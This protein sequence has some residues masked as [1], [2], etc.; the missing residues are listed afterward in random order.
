M[1][2]PEPAPASAPGPCLFSLAR[3][4]R[5]D[6]ATHLSSSHLGDP[7]N[8]LFSASDLAMQPIIPCEVHEDDCGPETTAGDQSH[9]T[10][11]TDSTP[12]T[13]TQSLHEASMQ[14]SPE[15]CSGMNGFALTIFSSLQEAPAGKSYGLADD[16]TLTKVVNGRRQQYKSTRRMM[17]SVRAL[18]EEIGAMGPQH[19]L[20]AGTYA[21][22]E[23]IAV[24]VSARLQQERQGILRAPEGTPYATLSGADLQWR[25]GPGILVIDADGYGIESA[26]D[27]LVQVLPAAHAWPM[28]AMSSSGAHIYTEAGEQLRGDTGCHLII[29]V[30]DATDVPRALLDL[31]RHMWLAGHGVVKLS[32]TGAFLVRSPVDLALRAPTQ[33]VFVHSVMGA[34]LQ[35]RKRIEVFHP[36]A[37]PV[38]TAQA[39]PPLTPEGVGTYAAKVAQSKREALPQAMAQRRSYIGQRAKDIVEQAAGAGRAVTLSA[40]MAQAA[41]SLTGGVLGPDFPLRTAAGTITVAEVLADPQSWNGTPVADPMEPHYGSGVGV[42]KVFATSTAVRIHSFAHGGRTYRLANDEGAREDFDL[43]AWEASTTEAEQNAIAQQVGD[44]ARLAALTSEPLRRGETVIVK[45]EDGTTTEHEAAQLARLAFMDRA[46]FAAGD[47]PL[48]SGIKVLDDEVLFG[49]RVMVHAAS[50][51][52]DGG[53]AVRLAL[54]LGDV[55]GLL[56]TWVEA[57]SDSALEGWPDLV[58]LATGITVDSA[59]IGKL[60]DDIRLIVK[61]KAD[62]VRGKLHEAIYRHQA[63]LHHAVAAATPHPDDAMELPADPEDEAA[64]ALRAR[65]ARE[66][67]MLDKA[68]DIPSNPIDA[69]KQAVKHLGVVGEEQAV[70]LAFL[71]M[72]SAALPKPTSGVLRGP[73]GTG[74]SHVMLAVAGLFPPE[75]VYVVSSMSAKAIIYEPRSFEHCTI[76]LLEA[77]ALRRDNGDEENG[78]AEMLRV[79]LSEGFLQHKTVEKQDGSLVTITKTVN[80]PT[81]LLTSTTRPKLDPELETRLLDHWSDTTDDH[82]RAVLIGIAE[83]A[84]GKAPP[85]VNLAQWH[86]FIEWV[87]TGAAAVVIP[88]ARILAKEFK[89]DGSR[90]YR[91]FNALVALTKVVT[92]MHRGR[93]QCDAFGNLLADLEDYRVVHDILSARFSELSGRQLPPELKP[94]FTKVREVLEKNGDPTLSA[95]AKTMRLSLRQLAAATGLSKST[96]ERGLTRLEKLDM[97]SIQRNPERP[98]DPPAISLAPD[99]EAILNESTPAILHPDRLLKLMAQ[100]ARLPERTGVADQSEPQAQ[101]GLEVE[102][103]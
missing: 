12:N 28:L 98:K 72:L 21:L 91:D 97:I 101:E 49:V 23:V 50:D 87:H 54:S 64:Q 56:K 10:E 42:A 25:P 38:S 52:G 8:L 5:H 57:D 16:G 47:Q 1:S 27:L 74:K 65:L 48:P 35:Q 76:L 31:H 7:L 89:Q 93:R 80:G 82:A 19:Y 94:V 44:V 2:Y 4:D 96:L 61:D 22:P 46:K 26:R 29:P 58:A 71:I 69:L 3:R 20:G 60:A 102:L 67:A 15:H 39:I 34:G 78:L 43:D 14:S 11:A 53:Q 37:A 30:A 41:N 95:A 9:G 103:L 90:R 45:H 13:N 81:N 40:A 66:R 83:R 70:V 32:Q 59:G 99:A 100:E 33:P 51:T 68:G 17:P 86:A 18:A 24:T 63:A 36:E 62:K 79:L 75:R 73:P 92:L 55:R 6:L 88:F 85:A 77:E 84:E